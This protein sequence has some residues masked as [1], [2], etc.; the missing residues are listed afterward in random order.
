MLEWKKLGILGAGIGIGI[1]LAVGIAVPSWNYWIHREKPWN[2]TAITAEYDGLRTEGADH[3]L[4]FRYTLS[5]NTD[6]DF[7]IDD[8]SSVQLAAR[9]KDKNSLLFT[10]GRE[11]GKLDLP[12]FLPEHSRVRLTVH[13]PFHF[14]SVDPEEGSDDERHDWETT[15]TQF[16]TKKYPNLG[17]FVILDS[18]KRY[19]IDLPSGWEKRSQEPFKTH[20][21]QTGSTNSP[22][23]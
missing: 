13:L 5:N 21:N 1:V 11:S 7:H 4:S 10:G 3:R 2:R 17:G 22:S 23:K 12:V 20:S 6:R 9:L 8:S 16:V 18:A 15:V 14:I 19:E